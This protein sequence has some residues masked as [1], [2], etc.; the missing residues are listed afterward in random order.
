LTRTDS[1]YEIANGLT[2]VRIISPDA[3]PRP[4]NRAP[5]QGILLPGGVW[6]GVGPSPNLL[7][8]EREASAGQIGVPLQTAMPD[9]TGYN[10]EIVDSGPLKVVVRSTY[11]FN[12][13]RYA[14]GSTVI[15]RAGAGHYTL[16]M[17]MYAN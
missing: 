2:G 6:T 15:N 17:T 14:Y 13:P 3:N 11:K 8:S 10:V 16:T 5:I 4:W 9:A 1:N 12:R 7:Y